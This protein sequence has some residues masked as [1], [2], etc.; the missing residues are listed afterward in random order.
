MC[1]GGGSGQRALEQEER[2]LLAMQT[3]VAEQGIRGRE[4]A[5]GGYRDFR[6]RGRER[7]SIANQ[8]LEA[9][10]YMQDAMAGFG[11]AQRMQDARMMSMGVN[12]GDA[13][14]SRGRDT[15]GVGM[16]GQ[17]AAGMNAAR[18]G[19]RAEGM[20]MEGAGLAGMAGFDPSNALNSMGSTIG[21][22]QRTSQ[23]AD[24]AET[25]GWGQLGS[26][27]M[28]GLKNADEIKKGWETFFGSDGGEVPN[29]AQGG[30]VRGY[31][32]GGNVYDQAT[33]QVAQARAQGPRTAPQGAAPSPGIDPLTATRMA[34]MAVDK[35]AG[36]AL[37]YGAAV[38][39]VSMG[40]QQAAMLAEQT[41]A[42]GAQGLAATADAAA[43]AA[44]LGE[45]AAAAGAAE[46]AGLAAGAAGAST[47]L[48]AAIP[49]LGLGLLAASLFKD[50]GP[51]GIDRMAAGGMAVNPEGGKVSG[52]GGPKDDMV[53]AYL[54]PGEFVMPVGAVKKYG[55]DRLEK[56]RQ[57]G[58]DFERQQGIA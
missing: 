38:P 35:A 55:L 22:A 1:G 53:P 44:G 32:Q 47:A 48:G 7:G 52:P 25:A 54:S 30:L 12:P 45:A 56:M 46:G 4:E 2:N 29:Y 51:V 21:N 33:Q 14:F 50:G 16:A 26:A 40:S 10:R 13:R 18:A 34:K 28:Y 57:D 17:A 41:G 6:Q 37:G 11:N 19:A 15:A 20:R 43:G 23:A 42:F 8:D 49:I 27:A 39:G 58:L 5:M 31:A 9:G 24:A 36:S 3:R